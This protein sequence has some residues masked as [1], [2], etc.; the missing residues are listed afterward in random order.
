MRCTASRIRYIACHTTRTACI[1]R[2]ARTYIT[3][4]ALHIRCNISIVML[5]ASPGVY[6]A[7]LITCSPTICRALTYT[8]Y[9][10]LCPM[11]IIIPYASPVPTDCIENHVTATSVVWHALI[12]HQSLQETKPAPQRA[13]PPVMYYAPLAHS[14]AQ[15]MM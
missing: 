4:N 3:C 6:T 13:P 10:I 15:R 5:T 7:M 2:T 11:W 8:G 14:C 12:C 1:T 9:H